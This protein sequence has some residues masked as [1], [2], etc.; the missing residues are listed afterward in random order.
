MGVQ[1]RLAQFLHY[2][3]MGADFFLHVQILG[4]AAYLNFSAGK[5][6]FYRAGEGVQRGDFSFAFLFVKVPDKHFQLRVFHIPF[7]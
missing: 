6:G 3:W 5:L 7:N 2:I 1:K 4:F